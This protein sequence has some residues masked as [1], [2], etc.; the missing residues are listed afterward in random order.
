M[1][2]TTPLDGCT[3]INVERG[4]PYVTKYTTMPQVVSD[5][6]VRAGKASFPAIGRGACW[7]ACAQA[8]SKLLTLNAKAITQ[9]EMREAR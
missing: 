1:R 9:E 8:V 3:S 7:T 2:S 5:R 4:E 6:P